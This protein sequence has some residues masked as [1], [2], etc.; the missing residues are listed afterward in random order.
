MGME[1]N[2]AGFPR[3]W[4]KIV[5]DSRG[6]VA[7]FDCCGGRTCS[8]IFVFKLLNNVFSDFTKTKCIITISVYNQPSRST[9]PGQPSMGRHNEYQSKGGDA[10][11][12]GSKGR[13]GS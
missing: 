7:L 3:G 6:S 9:Q 10:L 12:L 1:T 11:R 2:V 4:N 5:R 13:Y 8:K